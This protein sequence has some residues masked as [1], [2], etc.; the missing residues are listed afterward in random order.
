MFRYRK[1]S[2]ENISNIKCNKEWLSKPVNF[3]DLFDGCVTNVPDVICETLTKAALYGIF[4]TKAKRNAEIVKKTLELEKVY[5]WMINCMNRSS[6]D[7][8]HV[9]CFSERV[10]SSVMW[11]HYSENHTGFCIEYDL[12][13]CSFSSILFPVYYN[14]IPLTEFIDS[15]SLTPVRYQYPLLFKDSDWSYEYEWRLIY[16]DLLNLNSNNQLLEMPKPT[17]LYLGANTSV[18]Q[19]KLMFVISNEMNIP[20]YKMRPDFQDRKLKFEMYNSGS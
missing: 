4:G 2:F 8:V 3:N 1:F 11:A 9:C 20:L 15:S 18:E 13:N 10:D 5:E 19:D 6:R 16:Y 17:A 14:S 7:D 12:S